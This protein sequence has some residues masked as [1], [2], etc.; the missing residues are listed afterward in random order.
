[1]AIAFYSRALAGS[2]L[3]QVQTG[4]VIRKRECEAFSKTSGGRVVAS[5]VGL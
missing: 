2:E 4:G 3:G 5:L 1:M